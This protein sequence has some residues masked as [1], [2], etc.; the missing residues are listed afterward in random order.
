M[1]DP[2][3]PLL[4]EKDESTEAPLVIPPELP[5]LPL[6]DTVLFPNS[7]MPLAVAREASVRLI[8]EATSSGRMIGVFTQREASVEE[9]GQEDLFPIGTATHIHKMFKLPDGS[10]RLI[11]QGL[12]RGAA[13]SH[14]PDPPV[15]KAAVAMADEVLREEDHLE[16]DALQRNI[17]SNF[18]QVVSLSPLL[19][20]TS[21]R[22]L[23]RPAEH[24]LGERLRGGFCECTV[25]AARL[26]EPRAG[27]RVRRGGVEIATGRAGGP[28]RALPRSRRVASSPRRRRRA[29]RRGGTRSSRCRHRSD[30]AAPAGRAVARAPARRGSRPGDPARAWPHRP[31][32]PRRTGSRPPRIRRRRDSACSSGGVRRTACA[33]RSAAAAGASPGGGERCSVLHRGRDPAVGPG[34]REGDVAGT[35]LGV[36]HDVGQPSVELDPTLGRLGAGDR[37]PEERMGEAERVALAVENV[38]GECGL[39]QRQRIHSPGTSDEL[40]GGPRGRRDEPEHLEGLARESAEARLDEVAQ[41]LR[42]GERRAGAECLG[43]PSKRASQLDREERVAAG[44][45]MEAPQDGARV[46]GAQAIVE[47]SP[48]RSDGQRPDAKLAHVSVVQTLEPEL[49]VHVDGVWP[50]ARKNA[51]GSSPVRRSAYESAPAEPASSQCASSTATRSFPPHASARK[52]VT[53]ETAIV[54]GSG[55]APSDG[56]RRRVTA[57]ARRCGA[58]SSSTTSAKASVRRSRSAVN[59]SCASDSTGEVARTRQSAARASSSPARASSSRCR[60]HPRAAAPAPSGT[61]RSRRRS[62]R[63]AVAADS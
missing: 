58:G 49:V 16:I 25:V 28:R 30:A 63:L 32:P 6:R 60:L 27:A 23:P 38:G 22:L 5:V 18:Q 26:G 59:E 45:L 50:S 2:N 4:V 11:V 43:R 51:M 1:S 57:S 3:E 54:P 40:D 37:R 39:E 14:R 13:R 8:D 47:H 24:E 56:S 10:L 19:S 29:P 55:G 36:C 52:A 21:H 44:D 46:R 41:A 42:H 17:K 33:A 12:A 35:L 20:D 53:T 9:P 61:R 62:S 7:F 48:E 15:L 34:R 31:C